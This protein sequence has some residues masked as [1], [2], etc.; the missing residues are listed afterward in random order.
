MGLGILCR[1][2]RDAFILPSSQGQSVTPL[3]LHPTLT[4][5]HTHSPGCPKGKWLVPREPELS[6][7]S[8]H[9]RQSR[10]G[11]DRHFPLAHG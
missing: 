5:P 6:P 8:Q 2:V 3:P 1:L 4:F 11:G 10:Q 9:Q 7:G